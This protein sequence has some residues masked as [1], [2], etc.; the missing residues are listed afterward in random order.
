MCCIPG[1]SRIIC[2]IC[3]FCFNIWLNIV[4]MDFGCRVYPPEYGAAMAGA[5]AQHRG[6]HIAKELPLTHATSEKDA[7]S[8]MLEAGVAGARVVR[9]HC[10]CH[11]HFTLCKTTS[12]SSFHQIPSK[13]NTAIRRRSM[14]WCWAERGQAFVVGMLF[15]HSCPFACVTA[16][17]AVYLRGN[18]HLSIPP[19]WKY[20]ID[21][22]VSSMV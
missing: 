12:T 13:S 10:H 22:A 17:V 5:F 14:A 6:T 7:F 2:I 1:A 16:K 15:A 20:L 18:R 3:I 4:T 21:K 19:D 9:Y 11:C 8:A